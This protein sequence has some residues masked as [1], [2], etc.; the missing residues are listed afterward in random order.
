M[1]SPCPARASSS[2]S[3]RTPAWTVTVWET[4]STSPIW[5]IRDRSRI[6]R[7][8]LRLAAPHTPEPPPRGI[9]AVPV[10]LAQARTVATSSV[11]AGK[12]TAAGSASSSPRTRRSSSSVHESMAR[13]RS[14]PASVLTVPV[15][16]A[17]DQNVQGAH[18]ADS[19]PRTPSPASA[20]AAGSSHH[21][22]QKPPAS[23]LQ[24]FLPGCLA[25][26]R[27]GV[28][29]WAGA[30]VPSVSGISHPPIRGPGPVG[31]VMNRPFPPGPSAA[32]NG[33][34]IRWRTSSQPARR[35]WA[36]PVGQSPHPPPEMAVPVQDARRA[37]HP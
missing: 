35:E 21:R 26:F 11:L 33:T 5:S 32:G 9:T 8:G 12:T 1:V 7:A 10:S 15:G 3:P 37:P 18:Q 4:R 29:G 25:P 19:R 13:S 24:K 2:R 23:G 6:D 22:A 20:R 14:I 28:A 31:L 34:L 17:A 27:A 16:Q 30:G 36:W